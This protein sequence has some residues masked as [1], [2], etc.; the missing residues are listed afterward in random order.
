M[1][2]LSVLINEIYVLNYTKLNFYKPKMFADFRDL[3]DLISV[4]DGYVVICL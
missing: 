3:L 1:F 4:Q 2:N